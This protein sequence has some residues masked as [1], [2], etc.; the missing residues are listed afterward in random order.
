MDV[1]RGPHGQ[2][3]VVSRVPDHPVVVST[4]R[5]AGY[6]ERPVTLRGRAMMQRTYVLNNRAFTRV[7]GGTTSTA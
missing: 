4:G 3:V 7:Y 2:R 6:V 5:H 1:S